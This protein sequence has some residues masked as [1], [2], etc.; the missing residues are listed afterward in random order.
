M[1]LA[2][3][4]FLL[5]NLQCYWHVL[6]RSTDLEQQ[7]SAP[8]KTGNSWQ[9]LTCCKPTVQRQRKL[10]H[11]LVYS[12]VGETGVLTTLNHCAS[13]QQRSLLYTCKRFHLAMLS[14]LHFALTEWKTTVIT[15]C[16]IASL[17]VQ[18]SWPRA[19]TIK[20]YGFI[21]YGNLPDFVVS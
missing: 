19:C 3:R 7:F 10:Q 18:H 4:F 15:L 14:F 5:F 13:T 20:H 8:F 21:I 17:G 16:I 1:R 12:G 9:V 2:S 11:F 6:L